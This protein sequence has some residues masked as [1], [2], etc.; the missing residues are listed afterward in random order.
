MSFK[1]SVVIPTYNRSTLVNQAIKS[2]LA[3]TFTDYEII[4]IDDGSIDGTE[5]AL[6]VYGDRIRYLWQE[7]QGESAARNRGIAL[8]QGEYIALLDSD[9]LWEP[10]KLQAQV[11]VLAMR[12]DVSMVGCQAWAIDEQGLRL[13]YH[14]LGQITNPAQLSYEALREV[15][16]ILCS[17]VVVRQADL[18]IEPFS[19]NVHYGEDWHLWLRLATQGGIVVVPRPLARL[20]QHHATQSYTVTP[21][22]VDRRLADHLYI[23]SQHPCPPEYALAPGLDP[24]I[25]RV[26][27]RAALDDLVLGRYQVAHERL[28]LSAAN[29]GGLTLRQMG[30]E[31]A[32]DRAAALAQPS[33][34]ATDRVQTFFEGALKELESLDILQATGHITAWSRM[35][36]VLAA[37][38]RGVPRGSTT[39]RRNLLLAVRVDR[40]VFRQRAFWGGWVASMHPFHETIK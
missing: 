8:A 5:E 20:R 24:A 11:Q 37:L 12:S 36:M 2:V 13:S 34:V 19:V 40:G 6:T 14:Q 38:A 21:G 30:L 9:D 3:Q 22:A 35:Y 39:I 4:V 18:G 28:Q 23:L 26:Y 1:V 32:I 27:L 10:E 29:D 31:S 15:N 7:N 17:T 16:P 33:F 25:A